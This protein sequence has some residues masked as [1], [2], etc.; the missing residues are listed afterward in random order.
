MLPLCSCLMIRILNHARR[1]LR[2]HRR[3][4]RQWQCQHGFARLRRRRLFL[5]QRSIALLGAFLRDVRRCGCHSK[6]PTQASE[7]LCC[8]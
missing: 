7:P 4:R 6:A 2:R 8:L 5:C 3:T 1:S